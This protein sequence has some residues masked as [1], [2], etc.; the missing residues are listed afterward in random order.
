MTKCYPM[1]SVLL[2]YMHKKASSID[3]SLF[4]PCIVC[5]FISLY[6][7][8][9]KPWPKHGKK[10][11]GIHNTSFSGRGLGFNQMS[12]SYLVESVTVLPAELTKFPWR[13]A[14]DLFELSTEVRGTRI[15]Q[16]KGD[17]GHGEF[18]IDQ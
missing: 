9:H 12:C 4:R 10:Q 18:V 15:V 11:V 2:W 7:E 16:T 13:H 3:Y 6:H 17:F 1:K 8:Q 5:A 14:R